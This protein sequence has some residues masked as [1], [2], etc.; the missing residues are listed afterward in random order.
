MKFYKNKNE[1]NKK[2]FLYNISL[3]SIIMLFIGILI[4]LFFPNS[5]TNINK[6]NNDKTKFNTIVGIDFGSINSGY[7]IIFNSLDERDIIYDEISS[8]IILDKIDGV[9]LRIGGN[10]YERFKLE[11]NNKYILYFSSLIKNFDPRINDN[12]IKSDYSGDEI[13]LKIVVKE[14][15]R[16]TK[17]E[18]EEKIKERKNNYN[19]NEIKWVI[20]VPPLWDIKGKKFMEDAAKKAGMFNLDVIFETEAI[21]SS[22]FKEDNKIVN[23]YLQKN[24]AFLI[25]DAGGYYIDFNA[26]R[27]LDD[28]NLEQL[29]NPVSIVNGSSFINEKIFTLFKNFVGEKKI[30]KN[31]YFSIKPIFD[32]IEN[33]IKDI[34]NGENLKLDI[35]PFKIQC[36]SKG[37]F[38]SIKNTIFPSPDICTKIVNKEK[39]T[40]D[41][42]GLIIPHEYISNIIDQTTTN[43]IFYLEH[44]LAKIDHIDL[45]VFTG[46]F[47]ANKI[48]KEKIKEYK[49]G[50]NSEII[51]MKEPQTAVMKGAALFTLKPNHIIKRIIPITIGITSYELKNSNEACDYEYIDENKNETRC[52]KYLILVQ[53]KESIKENQIINRL[54]YVTYKRIY[55]YYSY[56]KEINK[57]NKYVLG[58]IDSHLDESN[59][60]IKKLNLAMIFSNYINVS[61]IDKNLNVQNSTLLNYPKNKFLFN[62]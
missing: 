21:Y 43:I 55:I 30:K 46:G 31:D 33:W 39:F 19:L 60:S 52:Y 41:N 49:K 27:I 7:Y 50:H 9:G 12:L 51:F 26:Y 15:M 61:I 17:E 20:A 22:L 10:A 58:Y 57:E 2:Y 62:L 36:K 28:N 4:K 11:K 44:I 56:E 25:V 6:I 35:K 42:N 1:R 40:Y 59:N 23:K 54:I 32:S 48:F 13:K 37:V 14:F 5:N 16:K 8:Q 3:G 29:M 38:S 24:K 45:I 47:T 34:D 18:I 53:K